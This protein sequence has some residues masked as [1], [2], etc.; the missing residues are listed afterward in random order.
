MSYLLKLDWL[1][2]PG[3]SERHCSD[4][5]LLGYLFCTTLYIY[6]GFVFSLTFLESL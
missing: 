3:L 1:V 2:F 4:F 5:M 6:V